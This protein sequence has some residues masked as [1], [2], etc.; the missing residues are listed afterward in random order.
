VNSIQQHCSLIKGYSTC[1]HLKVA[2]IVSTT[3]MFSTALWLKPTKQLSSWYSELGSLPG[4]KEGGKKLGER[5][6]TSFYGRNWS[7]K[8][9]PNNTWYPFQDFIIQQNG[10]SGTLTRNN[11]YTYQLLLVMYNN[12]VTMYTWNHYQVLY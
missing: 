3:I 9:I 7:Q 10:K 8:N 4:R 5:R 6:G 11:W 2:R 12:P 1:I